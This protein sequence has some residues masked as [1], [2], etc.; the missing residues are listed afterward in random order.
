MPEQNMPPIDVYDGIFDQF[1]YN[2]CNAPIQTYPFPHF[3]AFNIFPSDFYEHLLSTLPADA[4]YTASDASDYNGR[5]FASVDGL[6][7]RDAFLSRDFMKRIVRMFG[8]H[9]PKVEGNVIPELR[10]IRDGQHYFIGP[11]TDAPWKLI[12]LLFYLPP[13]GS[14]LNDIGTSLYTPR[15]PTF[16]CLGGP[17]HPFELFYRV[18]TAPF[19]PNSCLGFLKTSHSFHGVEPISRHIQRD[20]LL[21]NLYRL[22]DDAP[23]VAEEATMPKSET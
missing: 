22:P 6:P 5:R 7:L 21:W 14:N 2:L 23:D 19:R 17:H 20:V 3:H 9:F 16:R 13:S 11:H 18:H 10:L 1:C 12:S 8:P 4:D 15:D